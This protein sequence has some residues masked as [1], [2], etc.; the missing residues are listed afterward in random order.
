MKLIIQIPCYNEE[1]DLPTTLAHLPTSIK[2]VDQI[3]WLVI[4]DGSTDRTIEVAKAHG[5][6]HVIS[7]T[8]NKGLA[9]TFQAGINRC[10]ELGA[11]II[12]NTDADNQY[13]GEYIADLIHPIL[14]GKAD[15][16]IANRQTDK[17]QHFSPLK[18]WLQ[19]LGSSV[20]RLV[21]GTS[22]P[23]AP[24]GFRA[25]SREAALRL[26]VITG[27]TYT[28]ETIIQ[29]GKR[30]L[31]I[32]SI[33]IEV[34]PKTRESRLIRSIPDYV[35]RSLFTILKLFILYEPMRF[36][37]WLS[38]PFFLIGGGLWFRFFIIW[39]QGESE[40]SSHIQS[41][42]VGSGALIIGFLVVVL[43][44][45]GDIIAINRR[46][47]EESL[48]HTKRL[49]LSKTMPKKDEETL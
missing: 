47:L 40:R 7:N 30:N 6:H 38:A 27:Y 9:I 39:I 34:N 3:E 37:L 48:Y 20:V 10:L 17:I 28:L 15:M 12:V 14:A 43:G 11:D 16:V 25:I 36:F 31:T 22:V 23:D 33:P 2:G 19:A 41:L 46:I 35:R 21:S 29:A 32:V 18:K 4:N 5:V 1:K 45:L 24:S 8:A 49:S 42:I 13:P 26:N 44:I